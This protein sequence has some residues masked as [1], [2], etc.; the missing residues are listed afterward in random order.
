VQN[1]VALTT[2][3]PMWGTSPPD[4]V[5][6]SDLEQPV[7][8]AIPSGTMSATA[9][10]TANTPPTWGGAQP[11]TETTD[12][13]TVPESTA[14]SWDDMPITS[15]TS[16]TAPLADIS[17]EGVDASSAAGGSEGFPEALSPPNVN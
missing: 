10:S 15:V 16:E 3:D 11:F 4:S 13:D 1:E 5:Y 9:P 8:S 2:S 17:C 6:E 12:S 14:F 7:S